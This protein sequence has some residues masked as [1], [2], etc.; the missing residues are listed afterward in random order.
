M[1]NEK[2]IKSRQQQKYDIEERWKEAGEK[3]FIPKAGEIIVYSDLNKIKIG[4]GNTDVNGLD[5]MQAGTISGS[6]SGSVIIGS[7]TASGEN[8]TVIG[9]GIASGAGATVIGS[10]LAEG[11]NSL[12]F[13]NAVAYSSNSI[14][15]GNDSKSGCKGFYWF[16]TVADAEGVV[17]GLK[18][19]LKQ[20]D[21]YWS[22]D[23]EGILADIALEKWL[24]GD[25][26]SYKNGTRYVLK[27]T[28]DYITTDVDDM[29]PIV[30][31][32]E[33]L[34]FTTVSEDA[35]IDDKSEFSIINPRKPEA[36]IIP[37]AESAF[38]VG[39]NNSA[40]GTASIAMGQTNLS[41]GEWSYTEGHSNTAIGTCSHAEGYNTVAGNG[42]AHAE[43]YSTNAIGARSH[44]EGWETNAIATAS[45]AEGRDTE[46]NAWYA[47]AEGGS[48]KATG[49]RSHAEGHATQANG[50]DS[51]A[52]GDSTIASKTAQHA[53][54]KFNIEDTDDT[55][56]F[57]K[58]AHIVGNGTDNKNR[59]NAHTLDWGGN[60]W[61]AGKVYTSEGG[62]S[63]YQLAPIKQSISND[64]VWSTLQ[65][66]KNTYPKTVLTTNDENK[67]LE[68]KPDWFERP[69]ELRT[70]GAGDKIHLYGSENLLGFEGT[71]ISNNGTTT[72]GI[73]YTFTKD[74]KIHA[75]GTAPSSARAS[76]IIGEVI[77][78]PG[79]YTYWVDGAST[80]IY[81]QLH[82]DG[83]SIEMTSRKNPYTFELTEDTKLIAR[84]IVKNAEVTVNTDLG[85]SITRSDEA[86]STFS[87]YEGKALTAVDGEIEVEAYSGTNYAYV[88][89]SS[90]SLEI[91]MYHDM[92]SVVSK[93]KSLPDIYGKEG[94]IEAS[95]AHTLDWNG[96]AWFQGNVYVG[97]D[98]QDNGKR[99]LTEDDMSSIGGSGVE[100]SK[101]GEQPWSSK[102]T[103][104]Q[105]CP[106]FQETG[107]VVVCEPVPNY[108][109]AVISHIG[110][111]GASKITLRQ[112][113]EEESIDYVVKLPYDIS[114]ASY[115]W[116]TGMLF[117]VDDEKIQLEPQVIT[118]LHGVNTFS[119]NCGNTTVRGRLDP[120]S[121][122]DTKFAEQ[123]AINAELTAEV[124]ALQAEQNKQYELIE[125]VTLVEDVASFKRT[126]DTNGVPYNL[127]ALRIRVLA[128][129]ASTSA[130]IIFAAGY[131]NSTT[132]LMYHQQSN[133]LQTS[134][135]ATNFVLRNDHGFVDYYCITSSKSNIG[136]AQMRDGYINRVWGNIQRFSLSTYPSTVLIPAGT[137][138]QIW[139]IKGGKP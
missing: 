71:N 109:L 110:E 76:R 93:A 66:I 52:E 105:L 107:N 88:I 114:D 117:T 31:F 83:S 75:E 43:G 5:F 139:G 4:D 134:E 49:L 38:S 118:A 59:S 124:D 96:N 98:N 55:T 69:V 89:P 37:F 65:T 116:T 94:Y 50:K 104:D 84:V 127:S 82:I 44:A 54:G 126:A 27:S 60:A 1:A 95:N 138:I 53:Q 101:I 10:G 92:Q 23:Q 36:G 80:D 137:I 68:F 73:T 25:V 29:L 13:N 130:Q 45:H 15:M 113:T 63:K 58:Y 90:S 122:W 132:N 32:T 20:N 99:L 46:A 81:G 3:G 14:A 131:G 125:E 33:E 11:D 97:G 100:D 106:F 39:I 7:G 103:V 74:G 42:Y 6:G 40:A 56:E 22:G 2:I 21:V 79:T 28:I 133:A 64:S 128:A 34:P 24:P 121:Y 48:S 26:V 8:S 120:S 12:A 19:T 47:H 86:P 41:A 18:L 135:R 35:N 17:R 78:P 119:S 123:E 85:F 70:T 57:G 102:N 77:L 67:I 112:D 62:T 87:K 9:S 30:F 129:A 136:T 108:P 16:E 72:G 51:H 61:Y 111:D 91:T 115:D